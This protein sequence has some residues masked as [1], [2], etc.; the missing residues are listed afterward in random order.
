MP[1]DPSVELSDAARLVRAVRELDMIASELITQL[2]SL[3]ATV[4][5]A[6]GELD[7]IQ[8]VKE[9]RIVADKLRS[10]AMSAAVVESPKRQRTSAA[11]AD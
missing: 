9:A 7:M 11:D 3:R 1:A 5:R 8:D 6:A 4:V 10:A 2:A